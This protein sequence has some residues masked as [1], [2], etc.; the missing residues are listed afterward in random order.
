MNPS[1]GFMQPSSTGREGKSPM[2]ALDPPFLFLFADDGA[3][4]CIY[5]E[6]NSSSQEMRFTV[7][8]P[9]TVKYAIDQKVF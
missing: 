2:E 7:V 9:S 5:I 3:L 8:R 1:A 4:L 6:Y